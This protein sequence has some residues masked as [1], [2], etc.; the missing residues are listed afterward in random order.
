MRS[1][2]EIRIRQKNTA[3]KDRDTALRAMPPKVLKNESAETGLNPHVVGCASK[4]IAPMLGPGSLIATGRVPT[5]KKL[6]RHPCPVAIKSKR[7]APSRPVSR[8]GAN[9]V[10]HAGCKEARKVNAALQPTLHGTMG[11][12]CGIASDSRDHRCRILRR[13]VGCPLSPRKC[14]TRTRPL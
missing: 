9:P 1:Q 12:P 2:N 14:R 11:V 13:P 5:P 3:K 4:Q 6:H 8:S 10:R 7:G